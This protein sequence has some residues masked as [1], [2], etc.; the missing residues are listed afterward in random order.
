MR[1][2]IRSGTVAICPLC[3]GYAKPDVTFFGEQLPD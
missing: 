1:E 3:E 2:H